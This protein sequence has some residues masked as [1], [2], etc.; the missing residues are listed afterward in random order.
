MSWIIEIKYLESWLDQQDAKTIAR[1]FEAFEM[2]Q[3]QGPS[4]GRPLVDS[5]TGS[6]LSNLK[7][8]RPASPKGT[9]IRILFAFDPERKAIMLFA[10]DKAKGKSG[11]VK[12]SGWYKKAIPLAE[13][14]FEQHIKELGHHEHE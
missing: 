5:I 8:L 10:G 9:E 12:W 1:I 2:L 3:S 7:E 6:R 13:K 11:K 4:L 14:L